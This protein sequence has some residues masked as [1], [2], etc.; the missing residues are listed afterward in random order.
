MAI[1]IH[2]TC[3]AFGIWRLLGFLHAHLTWMIA[4]DYPNVA[5]YVPDLMAQ[6]TLVAVNRYYY[7][8]VA[9]GLLSR[10]RS[11]ASPR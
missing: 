1:C 5:H 3:M 7:A 2:L 10:P 11:A 8:W 9:L 6:P 4:H